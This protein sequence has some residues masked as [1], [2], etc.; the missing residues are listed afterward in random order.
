MPVLLKSNSSK[1]FMLPKLAGNAVSGEL[2]M[3]ARA[4]V[5]VY[6]ILNVADR[7]VEVYSDPVGEAYQSR[8]D[9]GVGE[10]VPLIVDGV[11]VAAIPVRDV[12]P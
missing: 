4:G 8:R 1:F 10:S 11:E 6:W 9:Y 5:P 3:Y 7:A 12:F 2:S